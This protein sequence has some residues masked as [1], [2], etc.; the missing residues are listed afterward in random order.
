MSRKKRAA[1]RMQLFLMTHLMDSAVGVFLLLL[2][3]LLPVASVAA[4][5]LFPTGESPEPLVAVHT[6]ERAKE[7][8]RDQSLEETAAVGAVNVG[9]SANGTVH[10]AWTFWNDQS[11]GRRIHPPRTR[12]ET[13]LRETVSASRHGKSDKPPPPRGLCCSEN[14]K[15]S[16]LRK[17][18]FCRY[19][20]K[21]RYGH[22]AIAAA[23]PEWYI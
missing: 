11:R 7:N 22:A 18:E 4:A 14:N 12:S 10:A 15:T 6:A 21:T 23:S 13:N 9:T 2:R 17:T 20:D 5:V 19:R 16:L 3:S 8:Q 1:P